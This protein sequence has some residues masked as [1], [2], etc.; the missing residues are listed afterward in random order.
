MQYIAVLT[1]TRNDPKRPKTTWNDLQR[2]RNDLK[3]P[4]T[5]KKRPETTYDKHGITWN[6]LKR[7]ETTCNKQ[8]TTW[9]DFKR[10]YSN[11]MEPLWKVINWKPQMSQKGNR[12]I[13]CLQYFVSFVHMQDDNRQKNQ[14]KCQNQTKQSKK[15]L[16]NHLIS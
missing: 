8:G 1:K 6:D 15:T 12:S 4:T 2:E 7:P 11:F 14:I 13:P 10:T 16:N 9:N 3:R 5:S